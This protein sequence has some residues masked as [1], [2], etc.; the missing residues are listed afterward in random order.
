MSATY[1]AQLILLG[2]IILIILGEDTDRLS[3]VKT[4]QNGYHEP[5]SGQPTGLQ[6]PKRHV[7]FR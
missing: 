4:F 2:L 3:Y 1:P 7:L 5:L 6:S